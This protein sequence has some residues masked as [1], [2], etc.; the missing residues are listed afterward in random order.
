M[1]QPREIHWIADLRIL[2]YVKSSL[3]KG[4]MY[5][6][7]GHVRIFG[8]SDSGFAGDKGDMKSTTDY[9]TFVGGNLVTG[10]SKK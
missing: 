9:C 8:Y 10:R 5:K 1:Y 3:G 2:A 6:K 7:H 4:L